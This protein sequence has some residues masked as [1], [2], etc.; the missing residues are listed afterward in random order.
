MNVI[1]SGGKICERLRFAVPEF[2]AVTATR[3][4]LSERFMGKSHFGIFAQSV[5]VDLV[6][7]NIGRSSIP[8]ISVHAACVCVSEPERKEGEGR[9]SVSS[10]ST[11][12][13]VRNSGKSVQNLE[14]EH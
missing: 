6:T 9:F 2:G 8:M 11:C 3:E 12:V 1:W 5:A 13:S 10:L 7:N 14:L 4:Q